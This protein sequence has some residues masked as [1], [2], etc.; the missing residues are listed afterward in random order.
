MPEERPKVI[1][2]DTMWKAMVAAGVFRENDRIYRCII[3]M[4]AGHPV[5]MHIQ[6][7]DDERLLEVAPLL[8]A[9]EI[10]EVGRPEPGA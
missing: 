2:A 4:E 6:R 7:W 1:S 5:V 9:A 3:D 10:R 8:K